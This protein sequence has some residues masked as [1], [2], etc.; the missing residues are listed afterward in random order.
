MLKLFQHLHPEL[1]ESGKK[2]SDSNERPSQPGGA[3]QQIKVEVTIPELSNKMVIRISPSLTCKDLLN[4]VCHAKKLDR[5]CR[6]IRLHTNGGTTS[7]PISDNLRLVVN[8]GQSF[9]VCLG[10]STKQN[11]AI[12]A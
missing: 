2:Q 3:P 7:Q 9:V 1:S 5:T 4:I 8:V 6:E 10:K 12:V 11:D